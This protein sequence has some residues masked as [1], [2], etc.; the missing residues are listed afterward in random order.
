MNTQIPD[1]CPAMSEQS[2]ILSPITNPRPAETTERPCLDLRGEVCPYTFVRTKLALEE[3]PPGAELRSGSI[4]A[5]PSAACRGL[6]ARTA[7]RSCPATKT[8]T[9][10]VPHRGAQSL[11]PP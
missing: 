2:P 9:P 11:P 5:R 4:T 3:L 1:T 7:T 8:T 6:C 10:A